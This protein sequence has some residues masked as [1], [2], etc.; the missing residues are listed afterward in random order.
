MIPLALLGLSLGMSA[1]GA[2]LSFFG[3]RKQA[4][5]S[6]ETSRLELQAEAKRQQAMELDSRRKQMEILR[7]QQRARSVALTTAT[8]QGAAGGSAL[9]GAYGQVSGGTGVNLL[10]VTEN[11]QIGRDLFG[12][13]SQISQQKM[14][15]ADAGVYSSAGAGLSSLGKDL[16]GSLDSA[17]R[18]GREAFGGGNLYNDLTY[19]NPNRIGSFY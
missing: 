4:E 5:A 10:G 13:N 1:A 16:L 17:N 15:L 3:A 18:V 14:R 6:K 2:G 7:T 9:A 8:S 19:R 12:I 11:L